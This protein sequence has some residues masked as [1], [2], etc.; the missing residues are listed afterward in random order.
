MSAPADQWANTLRR[1]YADF[2]LMA[3]HNGIGQ[4]AEA[5]RKAG[6]PSL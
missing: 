3:K 4:R 6:P 5:R 1:A 2:R